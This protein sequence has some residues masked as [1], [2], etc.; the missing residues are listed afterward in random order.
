VHLHPHQTLFPLEKFQTDETIRGY[1][2]PVRA[3]TYAIK[4][5]VDI[6]LAPEEALDRLGYTQYERL[7]KMREEDAAQ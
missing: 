5:L 2:P 4:T 6:G 1:G 3:G 7:G